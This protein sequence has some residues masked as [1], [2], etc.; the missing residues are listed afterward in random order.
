VVEYQS[1]TGIGWMPMLRKALERL[2]AEEWKP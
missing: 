2:M 1:R